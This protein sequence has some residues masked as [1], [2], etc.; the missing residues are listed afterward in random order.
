MAIMM[1]GVV[2][3]GGVVF[4]LMFSG[5]SPP[6]RGRSSAPPPPS[7]P[8]PAA[9]TSVGPSFAQRQAAADPAMQAQMFVGECKTLARSGRAD[10]ALQKLS[11]AV[12]RWGGKYDAEIYFTMAIAVG[13]KG[14]GADIWAK[15]LEY[16]EKCKQLLDAGGSLAYDP[17]GNRQTNLAKSIE[18]ARLKSGR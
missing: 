18:Q 7:T 8:P 5:D 2:L 14:N 11:G 17:L 12:G 16:Y 13:Q 6:P 10:E 9:S 15:K 1:I 4:F 3:A